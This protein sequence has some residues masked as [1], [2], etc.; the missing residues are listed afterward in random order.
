M[1]AI[2][3]WIYR[4]FYAGQL[5]FFFHWPVILF[6]ALPMIAWAYWIYGRKRKWRVKYPIT[7]VLAKIPRVKKVK[8]PSRHLPVL[9]RLAVIS[10]LILAAMRPQ[11]GQTKETIHTQ[12]IDI[13][14]LLDISGS[15]TAEDFRPNRSEAAKAVLAR[16]VRQNSNDRMGLVVFSGMP[17]TQCP[18]TTDTGVL[19]EFI[20]QVKPGDIL[21]DG[22]AIGDAIVTGVARFTDK[23][24][25]S[26]VM[27]LLTD[28][29]HNFG[30]VDPPT[31]AKVAARMGVRIYT[32]GVGSAGGAPIPDPT[33]PGGFLRYPDGRV[34]MTKLDE[35]TLR[36]VASLTGG[37]YYR[38]EDEKTLGKIYDEI[39]RLETHEIESKKFT[40]YS[41]L[42]QYVLGAAL[43]VLLFELV[44]RW[45][46][47]RV[48]P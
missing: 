37:R 11:M 35:N 43:A 25:P 38:A 19:E 16:F 42:F 36:D 14:L 4:A 48:L 18:L 2:Q 31:A 34:I 32:I 23:N 5:R 21:Q 28:G 26:K 30:E 22:T 15:M 13:I 41:E 20:N 3:N 6:I 45:I 10:L 29:E 46:W 27:I 33:M 8:R 12:G 44:A 1:G 9:L 40:T 39:G 7:S 47:G 24:V 17:F